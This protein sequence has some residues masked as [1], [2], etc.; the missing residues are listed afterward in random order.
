[1]GN[2]SLFVSTSRRL[3]KAKEFALNEQRD[4]RSVIF[5]YFV[6]QPYG[7]HGVD[8]ASSKSVQTTCQEIA[9]PVFTEDLYPEQHEL[10]IKGAL[11]PHRILGYYDL[12]FDYFVTN[13]HI[14][15]QPEGYFPRIL[16]DGFQIDQTRFEEVI[17]E[18][19]YSGYGTRW[20]LQD[21]HLYTDKFHR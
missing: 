21:R 15:E 16:R 13:P 17:A 3:G 18:T 5:Y 6:P 11:F 4:K 7:H 20:Q 1:M 19:G 9:L 8:L 14:F 10:A 12:E 2:K